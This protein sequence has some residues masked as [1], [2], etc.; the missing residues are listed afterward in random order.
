MYVDSRL[1]RTKFLPLFCSGVG[2]KAGI[3]FGRLMK[4]SRYSFPE[5]K[6]TA[7]AV[8]AK[9]FVGWNGGKTIGCVV[10]RYVLLGAIT[11]WKW[12]LSRWEPPLFI[13]SQLFNA[14]ATSLACISQIWSFGWANFLS[15]DNV[16]CDKG[17]HGLQGA[18]R[19]FWVFYCGKAIIVG[20]IKKIG[21]FQHS[22]HF[23]KFLPIHT[24]ISSLCFG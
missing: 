10:G 23:H 5:K 7:H 15:C 8:Q 19:W 6:K 18:S 2:R 24:E 11:H 22:G 4:F 21:S 3:T 20:L 9:D 1:L 16:I 14:S 17:Y 13:A 12:W